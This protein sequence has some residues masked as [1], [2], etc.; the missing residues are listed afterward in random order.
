MSRPAPV[1]PGGFVLLVARWCSGRRRAQ[2][3]ARSPHA[4]LWLG[5]LWRRWCSGRRRARPPARS[6]HASLW[7]GV[8][9][10]EARPGPPDPPAPSTPAA[11]AVLCVVAHRLVVRPGSAGPAAPSHRWLVVCVLPGQ[12]LCGLCGACA[13]HEEACDCCRQYERADAHVHKGAGCLSDKEPLKQPGEQEETEE[14]PHA[15]RCACH[16]LL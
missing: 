9:D 3:P 2:P 14:T 15:S 10:L 6:P 7:L 4:S 8:V 5:W 12:A 11:P 13:E 16:Q 1:G